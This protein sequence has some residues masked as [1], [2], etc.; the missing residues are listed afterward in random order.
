VAVYSMTGYANASASPVAAAS[1]AL[2]EPRESG[3]GAA[4][5]TASVGVEIRSVNGRFLDLALRLPDEY[6]GLEPAL[7]E[8]LTARF[9]R[10]KVELRLTGGGDAERDL[11]E[12][13]PEQLDHLVHLQRRVQDRLRD[14]RAL[15]VHEVLQWCRGA[16]EA[17]TS[18]A[19]VMETARLCVERLAE[20]RA[21]EG[22]RLAA[23]LQERVEHL[24]GLADHAGAH[25]R[26][27]ALGEVGVGA[28]HVVGDHESEHGVAEELEPLVGGAPRHLGAPRPVGEGSGQQLGIREAATQAGGERLELGGEGQR[29]AQGR[30][31]QT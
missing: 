13:R 20:A 12:P 28:E 5:A 16:A 9:K 17:R 19:A 10:G 23:I 7:R 21:R 31:A 2:H 4:V 8:L 26:Q 11:P 30:R 14:A 18:E 24:R 6:R 29:G 22:A 1:A 15:S 25:H 27:L 3:A